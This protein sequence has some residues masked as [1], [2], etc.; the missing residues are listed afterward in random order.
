MQNDQHS[1]LVDEKKPVIIE[2][3]QKAKLSDLQTEALEKLKK[4]DNVL[5]K[6]G[7]EALIFE[8]FYKI[9]GKNIIKDDL[10]DELYKV[11]NTTNYMLDKI[12]KNKK[13]I[14][15]DDVNTKDK[16]ETFDDMIIKSFKETINLLSKEYGKNIA[17]WRWG[18]AHKLELQHPLGQSKMLDLAFNLNH[19]YDVGGSFHTVSPYSYG[20]KDNGFISKFGA[21]HRHIYSTADWNKSQTI[22]PT[23]ISDIPTSKHYCD[24]TDMY[25]NGVYHNDFIDI[26]KIKENAVYTAT[27]K[28]N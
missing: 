28:G 7:S 3:L 9:L 13:S 26:E 23:G 22:I 2:A 27:F 11:F 16:V 24:Q 6:D 18:D 4:W 14:L 21:S 12:F 20:L 10:G 5:S 17:K 8:Q 19:T 25:I 15:C 1:V